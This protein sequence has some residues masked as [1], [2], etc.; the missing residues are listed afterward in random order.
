MSRCAQP[1]TCLADRLRPATLAPS[2][3]YIAHMLL[4]ACIVGF[5]FAHSAALVAVGL[6]AWLLDLTIRYVWMA[7]EGVQS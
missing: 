7:G 3:R 2:F 4:A 1:L 5:A 6:V